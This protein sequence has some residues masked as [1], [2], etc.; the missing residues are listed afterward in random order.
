MFKANNL[1]TPLSKLINLD[2]NASKKY[3][4]DLFLQENF[5][6]SDTAAI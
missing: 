4:Y 1:I 5:D 3:W 6:A 2:V